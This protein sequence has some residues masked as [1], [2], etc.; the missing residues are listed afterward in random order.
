MPL[1]QYRLVSRRHLLRQSSAGESERCG[2]YARTGYI[3]GKPRYWIE[4]LLAMYISWKNNTYDFIVTSFFQLLFLPHVVKKSKLSGVGSADGLWT[5]A[6]TTGTIPGTFPVARAWRSTSQRVII[7]DTIMT[8]EHTFLE[9][10]IQACNKVWS[11]QSVE[12]GPAVNTWDL[13]QDC[14]GPSINS[15]NPQHMSSTIRAAPNPNLVL[16]HFGS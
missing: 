6:S 5:S 15:S 2:E 16:V 9:S 8:D 10:L 11:D 3:R 12:I 7:C 1:K 13:T 14:L 4:C